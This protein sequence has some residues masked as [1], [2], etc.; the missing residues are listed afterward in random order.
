MLLVQIAGAH[1]SLAGCVM[2]TTE[3]TPRAIWTQLTPLMPLSGYARVDGSDIALQFIRALRVAKTELSAYYRAHAPPSPPLIPSP[4]P[5]RM[6]EYFR[7]E[8]IVDTLQSMRVGSIAETQKLRIESI[9]DPVSNNKPNVMLGVASLTSTT[10]ATTAINIVVKFGEC[11]CPEAHRAAFEVG[12]APRLLYYKR[13]RDNFHL[14]VMERIQGEIWKANSGCSY[15]QVLQL[16][17]QLHQCGFVHGD[18]RKPN[19]IVAGM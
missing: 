5:P 19:V 12:I 11:Y 1:M 16:V 7:E 17:H 10:T 3:K 9:F 6:I 4:R 2:S 18:I 8:L 13:I 15:E 14:V